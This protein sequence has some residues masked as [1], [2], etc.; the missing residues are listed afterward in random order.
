MSNFGECSKSPPPDKSQVCCRRLRRPPIKQCSSTLRRSVHVPIYMRVPG[1][2]TMCRIVALGR[3]S[4]W[5]TKNNRLSCTMAQ[6]AAPA[7][8]R[9]G[10]N[11]LCVRERVTPG[12]MSGNG[13]RQPHN[14]RGPGPLLMSLAGLWPGTSGPSGHDADIPHNDRFRYGFY[15]WTAPP[16][17][18]LCPPFFCV[19]VLRNKTRGKKA[20]SQPRHPRPRL[21]CRAADKYQGMMESAARPSPNC[22]G[23]RKRDDVVAYMCLRNMMPTTAMNMPRV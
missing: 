3:C 21:V 18:Y 9:S 15:A 10:L 13:P 23:H 4:A 8:T 7:T 2:R 19:L 14:G 5:P 6:A 20:S 22:T 11:M 17:R 12:L 16:P 1:Y